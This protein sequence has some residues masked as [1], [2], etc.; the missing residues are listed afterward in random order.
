MYIKEP[1]IQKGSV[2][3]DGV[4]LHYSMEGTGIPVLVIGSA[5]Y[6]PRTFSHPLRETCRL[7]FADLRHFAVSDS[8]FNPDRITLDMYL[9]D[10]EQ[11]RTA[12]GFERT[13]L[14]GHSHH[15]NLALEYAKRH[16]ARVSHLALIGSPPCDVKCTIEAGERY[17]TAHA[18][19][20]RKARLRA[21]WEA[22]GP[23][24]LAMMSPDQAFVAEYVADGPKYWY[25]PGYDS[26]PLWQGVPVNTDIVKVFRD[27]FSDYEFGWN[28]GHLKTPV[29]VVMGR[30]DYMV[31]YVLWDKV[32]PG[33]QN[34]TFHL[35]EQSGHT[36]QAEEPVLFEQIFLEWIGHT[37]S[38]WRHDG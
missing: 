19:E 17:W 38:N 8:S 32:L 30:H 13:V 16:P 22:L 11:V 20:S 25:D 33:L 4:T 34:V 35:F 29:L 2:K 10:I 3:V 12:L 21:N 1:L 23:E 26:S 18:S 9:D 37:G 28:P 15:G 31:P 5:V 24:E 7:A 27:F 14:I 36:P 6:Y